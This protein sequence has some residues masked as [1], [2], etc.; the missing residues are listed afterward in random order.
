MDIVARIALM[1]T[2][3]MNNSVTRVLSTQCQSKLHKKST[4]MFMWSRV[5]TE[6]KQEKQKVAEPTK[7]TNHLS[8]KTILPQNILG[9]DLEIEAII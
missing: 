6:V 5:Q 9:H 3:P 1:L 2:A 8:R 7:K 4:R